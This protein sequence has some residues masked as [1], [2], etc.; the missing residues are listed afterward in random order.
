M[1]RKISYILFYFLELDQTSSS[2]T[3]SSHRR[4]TEDVVNLKQC[5]FIL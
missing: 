4:K 5:L 3:E 2:L 1:P